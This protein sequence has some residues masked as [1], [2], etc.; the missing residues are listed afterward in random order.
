MKKFAYTVL[1]A[2]MAGGVAFGT[3]GAA[4]AAHCVEGD[5]PGFSYF[6]TDHVQEADHAEG[7][8]P[9]HMGTPGASNCNA[10]TGNPSDRSSGK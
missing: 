1:T 9:G 6:G 5:S 3:G 7:N 4:S 8:T 2:A 10:T